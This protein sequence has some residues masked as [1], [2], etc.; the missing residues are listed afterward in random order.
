MEKRIILI[1]DSEQRITS[2]PDKEI[3]MENIDSTELHVNIENPQPTDANAGMINGEINRV[4]G[5]VKSQ[6]H[7]GQDQQATTDRISLAKQTE[8]LHLQNL[9]EMNFGDSYP[10]KK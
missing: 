9:S 2:S 3:R 7:A 6:L 10:H 4:Q 8:A 1:S 5:L